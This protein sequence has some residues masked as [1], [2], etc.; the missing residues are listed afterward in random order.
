MLLLNLA[1]VPMFNCDRSIPKGHLEPLGT[2]PKSEDIIDEVD[3]FL[4]ATD[5]FEKYQIYDRPVIFKGAAKY[6][7]AY[8]KWTDNYMR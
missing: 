6:Y 7:P 2:Y 5:F 1:N 3:G 8:N 4:S